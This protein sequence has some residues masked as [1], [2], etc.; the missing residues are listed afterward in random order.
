MEASQ[1]EGE[2][3]EAVFGCKHSGF[4]EL[5]PEMRK[6]LLGGFLNG[7]A[8]AQWMVKWAFDRWPDGDGR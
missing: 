5:C 1:P 3:R 6:M 7:T 4:A 8:E 2:L